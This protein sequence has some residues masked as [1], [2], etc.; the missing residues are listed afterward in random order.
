MGVPEYTDVS[1]AHRTQ[2][3]PDESRFVVMVR[4]KFYFKVVLVA[5]AVGALAALFRQH[6][7]VIGHGKTGT[8]EI[9]NPSHSPPT[10]AMLGAITALA[11]GRFSTLRTP[12]IQSI[13]VAGVQPK[14][15]G[16]LVHMAT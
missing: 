5:T 7:V 1:V 16:G 6:R 8:I 12:T 10:F 3:H 14:T 15:A 13:I 2:Q 11:L 9:D 4:C